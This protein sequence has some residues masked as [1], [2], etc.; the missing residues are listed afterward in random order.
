MSNLGNVGNI[1]FLRYLANATASAF[2][3]M[4]FQ[5]RAELMPQDCIRCDVEVAG[6]DFI[7]IT[8]ESNKFLA[9]VTELYGPKY[10]LP[11]TILLVR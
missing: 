8:E 1:V 9:W 10:E 2:A 3:N 5:A 4:I 6:T 7:I 11:F